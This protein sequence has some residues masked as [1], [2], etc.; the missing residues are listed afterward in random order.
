MIRKIFFF[1]T[2][3]I[4]QLSY[5]IFYKFSI[6]PIDILNTILKLPSTIIIYTIFLSSNR[7]TVMNP[8]P[9]HSW[10]SANVTADCD[11]FKTV[12]K[13]ESWKRTGPWR[14]PAPTFHRDSS[15]STP[16]TVLLL[17]VICCPSGQWGCTYKWIDSI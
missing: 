3:N 2:S 14:S 6:L 13:T 8:K 11:M 15:S 9:R 1:I 16:S 4:K 12:L 7:L 10:T 5:S 17:V